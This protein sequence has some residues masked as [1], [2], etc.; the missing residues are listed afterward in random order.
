MD[1]SVAGQECLY[2]GKP[3]AAYRPTQKYCGSTCKNASHAER[4]F[5]PH[6]SVV[7]KQAS[8]ALSEMIVCSDLLRKGY[9]VYRNVSASGPCDLI[10]TRSEDLIRVEVKSGYLLPSGK[11][12]YPKPR[13]HYTYDILAVVLRD[14]SLRYLT[15]QGVYIRF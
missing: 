5:S 13:P 11:L 2:C 10:A 8:G 3:Y 12:S 9:H 1:G 4:Y 15:P 6:G 14:D 7:D